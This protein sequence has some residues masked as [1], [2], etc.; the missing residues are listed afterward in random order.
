M[1]LSQAN[2]TA[3]LSIISELTD[4]RHGT[5]NDHTHEYNNTGKDCNAMNLESPYN[6]ACAAPVIAW[7]TCLQEL[8]P[9]T[10]PG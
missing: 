9:T 10:R 7:K 2:L 5:S 1:L 3:H 6:N 4:A 8:Q